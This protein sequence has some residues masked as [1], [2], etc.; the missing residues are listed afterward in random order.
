MTSWIINYVIDKYL[1]HIIEV[2][3]N[4][5]DASILKDGQI[6]FGNVKIKQ[7]FLKTLNMPFFEFKESFIGKF[8]A[9]IYY[10]LLR[11]DYHFEN[12][13]I[14][15]VLD[16]VFIHV[17]QKGM[18]D[19]SEEQKI[20]EMENFKNF[21]L[22]EWEDAYK[23]YL[24]NMAGATESDFVKKIIH[25]LNISISNIVIRFEDEISN[26]SNPYSLGLVISNI[27]SKPT[28]ENFDIRSEE[29][30]PFAEINHKVLILK[31]LS[32][33]MD[34]KNL[35]ENN[36]IS[37]KNYISKK[38]LEENN[39]KKTYL[40]DSFEYYCYCMSELN[41]LT[42]DNKAHNY[43]I[44]NLDLSIKL[45]MNQNPIKNYQPALF[46]DVNINSIN[47]KINIL[48]IKTIIK[49]LNVTK[50]YNIAQAGM[51]SYYYTKKLSEKEKEN[52]ISI[53]TK[54]FEERY[55]KN[56]KEDVWKPFRKSFEEFE[57][58]IR[59]NEIQ[60]MRNG[61][62]IKLDYM[63]KINDY[64]DKIGKLKPGFFSYFTSQK[65]MDQMKALEADRDKLINSEEIIKKLIEEEI[66]KVNIA[67]KDP[68]Q[69]MD[70]SYIKN[71]IKLSLSKFSFEL[72]EESSK[73]L[74]EISLHD[75]ESHIL[76]GV[77]SMQT[78]LYL[79]DF[80]INQYKLQE[81]IFNKIIE[82]VNNNERDISYNLNTEGN[83]YEKYYES[84]NGALAIGFE[85]N[86]DMGDSSYRI[87][88]RNT[89]RFYIYANLYSLKYI[90]YMIGEAVKSEINLEEVSK[91]AT[92]EGY[93]HI[94]NGYNQVNNILA[95][96]Y[97]HFNI[98]ADIMFKGPRIIVPQNII[99]KKN[100][101]CLMLS[102]GEFGLVSKLA[103]KKV[104][105]LDYKKITEDKK[106]YDTYDMKILGFEL[107][108]IDKFKGAAEIND[109]KKL[110]IIDKVDFEFIFSQIIEPKNDYRENF[111]IGMQFKLISLQVRDSQIEFL[112]YFLKY[113][114]EM[115]IQL[116][117]DLKDL[118]GIDNINMVNEPSS[119]KN[120]EE[121]NKIAM[122]NHRNSFSETN[123]VENE[124]ILKSILIEMNY[125][126]QFIF[127]I[128]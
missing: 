22:Q 92:D 101:K 105:N 109:T 69:E 119:E 110:N 62:N 104:D 100:K 2:D 115:N 114:N 84:K 97:Q 82:S 7:E 58:Q 94:Q 38:E 17:K 26:P 68:F 116:E 60:A 123:N 40:K 75:F 55:F 52:Y 11:L 77:F 18:S 120:I 91:Y 121:L 19:W 113:F 43:L 108:T 1:N 4:I 35:G 59:F 39:T 20:K 83:Q 125:L 56:S 16:E 48:Q 49:L 34:I 32:V 85:M 27:V 89:K 64:N 127:L 51:E 74:I 44:Y 42:K 28:K 31:G 128:Y 126:N 102:F 93:K 88:I 98:S 76:Q 122:E 15:I 23:Q 66:H 12:Y 57:T 25:N 79:G 99:D 112:M 80:C 6:E 5:T 37:F 106:L 118:A 10:S 63:K 67:E 8:T 47:L 41:E 24:M 107:L 33:F 54:Y 86:P 29:D 70:K 61:A 87:R 124:I 78:Y 71:D 73:E 13:P 72:F 96:E 3:S 9:K 14:Y 36:L 90:G 53:Y 111:R 30:I 95:G 21:T 117:K 103:P 65:T 81:T 45:S 46:S 50:T